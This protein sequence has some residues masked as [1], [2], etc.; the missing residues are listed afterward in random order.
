MRFYENLQKL[1]ENILPQR[2]Y[3][4]PENKDGLIDLNGIWQFEFFECDT[5][6]LCDKSGEIDV[7]SCW[8]SRGYEKPYYT[9]VTYPFP[10]DPPFVP[11]INPMGVYSR[12]FEVFDLTRKYYIVF[13][14][15][16]SCLEL[17]INDNLV[18]FSQGSRLQAEFDISEYIRKGVN[19][20]TAKVRKWCVGSYLEDQDCFRYNG[21]FRDVYILS[22][23]QN[24]IKDIDIRTNKNEINIS[25]QGEG[26]VSLFDKNVLLEKIYAKGN[27]SFK[28][29]N[30]QRWNAE[31][32]YLYDVVFEY[33]GE[34]IRQ[35]VGFAEYGINKN[36]AFTVN[37]IEVKLKGVNHHD[38]HPINGYSMT[39]DDILKDLQMMK[40]LNINCIRTAHY[41][42]H[43]KF[44][45]YCNRLGFYVMVE[46][47]LETHG[48][49]RRYGDTETRYDCLDNNPEWIGNN[50]EWRDAFLDRIIRTYERDKNNPCVFSW[51]TGNESGHCANHFEM[52]KWLRE[53]DENRIIHCEDA[54]RAAENLGIF[55]SDNGM[56]YYSRPDIHSKMYPDYNFLS[57]YAQNEKLTL[58][59]FLCEYSHAMGNGPGDVADYW[60]EIYK[61]PKLIGGCIWEWA[62]HV[63]IEN[64]IPKYGGDFN[65]LTSDSNFC[66]D[67]LVKHDRILKAGSLNAKYVYQ[68]VRFEL[69]DDKIAITNLFDFTNLKKYKIIIDILVDGISKSK[70][71]FIIDLEPKERKC[72][73]ITIPDIAN[74]GAFAVCRVFDKNEYEI[75]MSEIELPVKLYPKVEKH[76][77]N[78]DIKEFKS[79]FIVL[80]GNT[81]Y[82]ISK[83]TGNIEQIYKN[84]KEQLSMPAEISLWRP[85]ID[86][87]RNLAG[88]WI[89][90]GDNSWGS[91]NL[92]RTFTKVYKFETFENKL[93]FEC[94]IAGVGHF[95][96]LKYTLKY[97]FFD[98]GIVDVS[99]EGNVRQRAFWLQRIGFDFWL[100]KKNASFSYYGRG[101]E[102]NYSDMYRHTTTSWYQSDAETEH[103][104]YTFPQECGNHTNCKKVN[105][106]S[107]LTFEATDVFEFKASP[108]SP[109]DIENA[110]HI[111]E[112]NKRGDTYVRIDYKN[113][114]IGS[115]SCGPQLLEKYRIQEKDIAFKFQI[116]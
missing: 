93:I 44:L 76:N 7:P 90:K 2:S 19:S 38:T 65:E 26:N 72:I 106:N 24:H 95:P 74:F 80:V 103:K 14:G 56:E 4:I 58:P 67:G 63:F 66:V 34:V 41:P 79:S 70:E 10:I 107:S 50:P 100:N 97:E 82:S 55:E 112:L 69:S 73:N 92:D 48:F 60:N 18:G 104:D 114:G 31:D 96:I 59:L 75:A 86:N 89:H 35:Q 49:V 32:P 57:E 102:E 61:Y 53:K 54:S 13:E 94:S 30:P 42:P 3:Y 22:R 84:N 43:P 91:E 71:E 116:S 108:Y 39:D 40:K 37:G 36:S 16:S 110:T 12:N 78:C 8:Q 87:E 83:L 17:Y 77:N 25:F 85:H 101:P 64:D 46:A 109:I 5:K 111:D 62:D 20:I 15:V 105:I 9:N 29:D 6:D 98:D 27:V 33:E 45:E 99:L 11:N 28:V 21:I 51:S 88:K 52:I 115:N 47:D 23:P 68:N 81:K 113:S 1:H